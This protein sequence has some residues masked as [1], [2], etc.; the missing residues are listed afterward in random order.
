MS[1][2][3]LI[4]RPGERGEALAAALSERGE[5]V[6]SLKV[7]QLEALPENPEMR[8]IWLDIDQYHKI[9]VISPFAASCLSEAMDRFWPQ[10]PIGIDYYSVGSATAATLYDQLGVRVHVPSPSAGEDTSEALLALASLQQLAHQRI[11]LV[12]GEGGRPLLAETLAERGAQV[13]RVAVYRRT[14]HPL[15]PDLQT[16]LSSG[17][18]RALIVT[19]SELLEHLAKWCNQAALNQP[20]IVSS[21]RLATLA[22]ILGFCDLK[23]ASGATPAAL[24]AA[25]E[26]CDPQGADVDQ[27]TY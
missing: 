18:Y 21:R 15:A 10:L 11:L 25:L 16:R 22:G 19:S 23:V 5:S 24:I 12:A 9:I 6:E 3:V 4:C 17:N 13:T 14:F 20:L 8:R 7:M 1:Q 26:T 2:P 27:G